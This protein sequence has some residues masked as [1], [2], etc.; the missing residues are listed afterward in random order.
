[1]ASK[2]GK[3]Y[4][5]KIR[6][7]FTQAFP[8]ASLQEINQNDQTFV[9]LSDHVNRK[10]ADLARGQEVINQQTNDFLTVASRDQKYLNS[11]VRTTDGTYGYVTG[12]GI[13]KPYNSEA[14][15][16]Q[17]MG[18]NGCPSQLIQLDTGPNTYTEDGK[19]VAGPVPFAVGSPMVNKQQCGPAGENVYVGS[20]AGGSGETKYLGCKRGG[21]GLIATGLSMPLDAPRCPAGTFQCKSN[22]QG[23]CYDPRRNQMVSTFRVPQYDPVKAPMMGE[24]GVT[25]LWFRQGGFDGACGAKPDVP[26]CPRGTAGCPTGSYGTCWDPTRNM[27]VTTRNPN[28][29]QLGTGNLSGSAPTHMWLVQGR[30]FDYARKDTSSKFVSPTGTPPNSAPLQSWYPDGQF[31]NPNSSPGN[32][33]YLQFKAAA[34]ASMPYLENGQSTQITVVSGPNVISWAM[35]PWTGNKVSGSVNIN[36]RSFFG[37]VKLSNVSSP[38]GSMVPRL[39]IQRDG[40]T[41]FLRSPA[42]S[43]WRNNYTYYFNQSPAEIFGSTSG[44]GFNS[45]GAIFT[46]T[47]NSPSSATGLLRYGDSTMTVQYTFGQ[48]IPKYVPGFLSQDGRTYLWKVSDGYNTSCGPRP[49]VPPVQKAQELLNQCQAVA[50]GGGFKVYGIMGDSC[51]VGKSADQLSSSNNCTNLG[52][53]NVGQGSDFAAYEASGASNE[54]L[55]KYGFVTADQ[56]L[57]EYPKNMLGATGEYTSVGKKTIMNAKNQQTT[58]NVGGSEQCKSICIGKFG[59][60]CEAFRYNTGSRQ[61]DSFGAES[62]SGGF[63]IPSQLDGELRIQKLGFKNDVSC[64]KTFKTIDSSVWAGM[65]KDGWMSPT[66]KCDLGKVTMEAVIKKQQDLAE[67]DKSISQMEQIVTSEVNSEIALRPQLK[68]DSEV[69]KKEL[70]EYKQLSEGLTS[71]SASLLANETSNSDSILSG[72]KVEGKLTDYLVM[73]GAVLFAGASL[74]K[75]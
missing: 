31:T 72:L 70:Q 44:G 61:C 74:L 49:D 41:L 62:L 35:Q 39:F 43:W 53:A 9:E 32:K 45:N 65:P 68:H 5:K 27:M 10:V 28:P 59:D 25:P 21:S 15:A 26:P 60:N 73:G 22:K 42:P 13:F 40:N 30:S 14:D 48:N 67:L 75:K 3:Q 34:E 47:K 17:T 46:V 57:K 23:Y 52:G 58:P 19:N 12:E 29:T 2:H 20:V 7:G 38:N 66:T 55:F 64:P 51:Y 33:I 50:V 18:R 56:T 24:D 1:M 71:I 36:G 16:K 4:R 8:N 63:M 11:N 37:D 69:L 6:E 54:G